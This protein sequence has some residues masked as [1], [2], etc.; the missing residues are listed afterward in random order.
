VIAR[1]LF[2]FNV[3]AV[4]TPILGILYLDVYEAHLR[5]A[6]EDS[7]VQES[8]VLA[9]AIVTDDGEALDSDRIRALLS[10]LGARTD[11]R[12]RVYDRSGALVADSART[13]PPPR[14]GS[15]KYGAEPSDTRSRPLYRLGARVANATGAAADTLR[16]WL[17]RSKPLAPSD[18]SPGL[19]VRAA[20]AGRYGATI[21]ST[22]GQR[23]LTMFSAVPVQR[24]GAVIGAVLAS[25]STFRILRALY[26]VR[27]RVFEI[28]LASLLV[29]AV[30]TAIAAGTIVRPLGALE[31]QASQIAM[32]RGRSPEHF[33][34][35][36]RTDELGALARAL[37]ALTRRTNGHIALLQSF[38]AD[39]SHE[40]KNPLASIRA[41][42]ETMAAADSAEERARFLGMMTRDVSRLERLV[43]SLRK[44][45]I[46]ERDI[47][48]DET[49]PVDLRDVCRDVVERAR[50]QSSVPLEQH[51]DAPAIVRGSF[52]GLVQVVDNLVAN[53]VSFAAEGT[54]VELR[55]EQSDR[56]CRVTVE[57]RGPGIPDS[58]LERVFDR[59]FSYRPA[60]GRG[61]H[62]GLGLAIARQI[63]ESY[64]GSITAS[65]REGGGARFDVR[66]PRG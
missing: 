20:L 5:Q 65:N 60:E 9:A 50:P 38:S 51:Q 64:G 57:D 55:V 11:A 47:A 22:P 27:L 61:G 7:M 49:G 23:S 31:R 32:H 35:S 39:V 29:A 33:A 17:Q 42:A 10:N 53:A 19:E 58:H 21:R 25:Q 14:Q 59:F 56:E 62:V 40:L 30:L 15:V 63:V 28:V 41:A 48:Q 34:G 18:G 43:S 12:L 36:G 54:V 2:A 13:A 3:L 37:E 8:R 44:I 45:A 26:D 4:F 16:Y 66:F 52:D 1:R 46:V 6:Q 24:N